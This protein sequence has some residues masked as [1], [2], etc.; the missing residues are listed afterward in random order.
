MNVMAAHAHFELNPWN[1]KSLLATTHADGTDAF[2]F[3]KVTNCWTT[4][5]SLASSNR[6]IGIELIGIV[7]NSVQA[8]TLTKNS[9]VLKHFDL[10]NLN[11]YVNGSQ[12]ALGPFDFTKKNCALGYH[13][14]LKAS[15]LL[16]HGESP[17]ITQ[18][19]Y[20]NGYALWGFDLS[21]EGSA[22]SHGTHSSVQRVG[23]I[24]LEAL[25]STAP[26]VT[27]TFLTY[28]IREGS[29]IEIDKMRNVYL[30]L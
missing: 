16:S 20:Q 8:G 21:P 25:F 29:S 2:R 6:A 22:A 26:T 4:K 7:E 13:S 10:T 17:M 19:R 15:G 9:F 28:S 18:E 24:R 30:S 1:K 5:R 11:V 27:T 3:G 14:L 12:H 23:S